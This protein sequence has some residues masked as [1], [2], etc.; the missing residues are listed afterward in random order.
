MDNKKTKLTISGKPKKSFKDFDTSKNLGKK[1]VVIDKQINKPFVKG[2][3]IRNSGF[4]T[5]SNFK[6]DET[7]LKLKESFSEALILTLTV[8]FCA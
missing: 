4:K 8:S 3:G 6:V 1:T 7:A 2:T 5:S